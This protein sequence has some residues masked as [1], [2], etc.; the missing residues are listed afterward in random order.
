MFYRDLVHSVVRGTERPRLL[1]LGCALGLFLAVLNP[2]WDLYGIDI[3]KFGIQK[4]KE[5]LPEARVEVWDGTTVP[6]EGQFKVIVSFDVLEHI[7]DLKTISSTIY[8]KLEAGGHFIFVVP[9]YDGPTGP[10]IRLLDRDETHV[11]RRSRYFWLDWT[12]RRF[13]VVDWWGIYR[14]LVGRRYYIHVP[15]KRFRRFT[16]AIAVIAQRTDVV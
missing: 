1:E 3:S 15:T 11:H 12:R 16:P 14:W 6:F 10:I 7:L 4:A 13:A 8:S 5:S 9:V 2:E